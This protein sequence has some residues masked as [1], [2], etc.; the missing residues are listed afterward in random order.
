M[1]KRIAV[2]LTVIALVTSAR[3]ATTQPGAERMSSQEMQVRSAYA[4][5]AELNRAARQVEG[6]SEEGIL[7]FQLT[8]FEVGPIAD[9]AARPHHELVTRPSERMLDVTPN[10]IREDDGPEK[11]V[12]HAA[13]RP[14]IFVPLYDRAW[15][16]SDFLSFQ[17][18]DYYD[19]SGYASYQVTATLDGQSQTYRAVAIFHDALGSA[20]RIDFWDDVAGFGGAVTKAARETRPVFVSDA[21]GLGNGASAARDAGNG[22]LRSRSNAVTWLDHDD[23][24]HASGNHLGTAQFQPQCLTV[25]ASTQRCVVNILQDSFAAYDSGTLS[26]VF[27]IYTHYSGKNM[28]TNFANGPKNAPLTC[29]ATAGVGFTSC[30]FSCSVEVSF[31]ALGGTV[32]AQ[33]GALWNSQRTENNN[34]PAMT[35]GGG[36]GGGGTTYPGGG[37][38]QCPVSRQAI[39]IIDGFEMPGTYCISPIVIDVAGNGFNLTNGPGGVNF[40]LDSNGTA[41]HLSWTA[42]GSDD[43][44]LVLDRNG[45]GAIDNGREL[46]GNF[47]PQSSSPDPNGFVALADFD[48]AI[49]GG[50]GDGVINRKDAVFASLRLWQDT[51]H[52]GISEP[53]ELHTLPSLGVASLDLDYRVSNRKDE[54]GNVFRYRA[55]VRDSKDANVGRW[56]WDVY[57]TDK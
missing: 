39:L 42:A 51:N 20:A 26:D 36:G 30:I 44:F 50:N 23:K 9:I 14:G 8:D 45:N 27:G 48:K 43:A 46:F 40:D 31:S 56:A 13:W 47:T 37:G 17:P 52:N 4:K 25:D 18:G 24:E 55:K 34:C 57:L 3:G 16:V 15:T 29:S 5:F 6:K 11:T 41:E 35:A 21:V 19:A 22:G 12:Y 38:G 49:N 32:T 10:I 54:N 1:T 7:T 28:L 53:G 33:G 2:V